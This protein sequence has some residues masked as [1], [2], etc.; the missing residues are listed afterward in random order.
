MNVLI[1]NTSENTGGA[2]VAANRLK[3]ALNMVGVKAKMLVRDK[4][5]DDITV[6]AL[7]HS[8][9]QK[10]NFLWERLCIFMHLHLSKKH[11]FEIDIANIG[12]DITH[13]QV[14]R[15]AD[16]IH[17]S[18]INQ[19]MLS[20]KGIRKIIESGK[21]VIWTMHDVWP[22]TGICH[23]PVD[24]RNF[25][26]ECGNC[27]LL[28]G[29]G[30]AKDLSWKRFQLKK[31]IYSNNSIQF[32]TCSSWLAGEAKRSG[33]L[34]RQSI[35]VIP[36]PIDTRVFH[37]KDKNEIRQNLC[38]P[39]DKRI[40]LF[41]S[42]RV[43]NK[44]KGMTYFIEAL[45][46]AVAMHPEMKDNTAVAILG[47]HAEEVVSDI[48][49]ETL[50]MGYVSDEKRIVDVYNVAD[51]FVT[52]SLSDNLPNTIMEA[53]ACG[54]PC[55]GFNVGGIPEEIDHKINGYVAE[56]KNADDLCRGICWVLNDADRTE[57]SQNALKKVH[58]SYS[59]RTVALKYI[60]VYSKA[61]VHKSYNL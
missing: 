37:Q 44:L 48:P 60:D 11:L 58:K 24:C 49:M 59:P 7:P 56:Y 4:S 20:L 14:F 34:S 8:I 53:M 19:G 33:I 17:L 23:Y 47:S 41:A 1:I 18:W 5:T 22:A 26:K 40:I 45:N 13:L 42:Q 29:E 50:P 15:E 54:V 55:V 43:T 25:C 31:R 28:P 39:L 3:N 6:I 16:V 10:I 27:P 32:V 30:N 52:P 51:V 21:P 36:N 12:T 35:T 46:K 38:L 61:M 2:A 9:K 57:L